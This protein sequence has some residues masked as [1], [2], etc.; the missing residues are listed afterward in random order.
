MSETFENKIKDATIADVYKD[1]SAN[2]KLI[3]EIIKYLN[4]PNPK[5]KP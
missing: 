1:G 4:N 3:M 2:I 5:K